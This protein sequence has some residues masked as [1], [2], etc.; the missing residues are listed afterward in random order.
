MEK[1]FQ[2]KTNLYNKLEEALSKKDV[3]VLTKSDKSKLERLEKKHKVS[4]DSLYKEFEKGVKVEKEHMKNIKETKKIALDHLAED[5][6]Y[7]T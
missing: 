7:Y 3:I 2:D 6:K 5:P 1:T 4:F